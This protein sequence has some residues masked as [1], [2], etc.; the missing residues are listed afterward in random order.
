MD[1][2]ILKEVFDLTLFWE[3]RGF[4]MQGLWFNFE[5]FFFAW[6]LAVAGGFLVAL[7]RISP[8][9][10][11]QMIGT[12]YVELFRNLPDYVFLIW[13]HFVLPLLISRAI[14]TNVSFSPILSAVLG[15][16]I[17]YSGY[18]T[19][20]FRAGFQAVPRGHIKAGQ[21]LGM[22]GMLTVRRIILPQALRY[23][24][25]EVLNNSVSLFK[26]TSIVSLIAVPD[27]MYQVVVVVQEE[28]RPLSLYT[29]AALIYFVLIFAMTMSVR[30]LTDQWRMRGWA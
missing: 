28:M 12:L 15:L 21:S 1:V 25:P 17:S 7:L 16:G 19:E 14:N 18:L 9:R 22:H 20:T 8:W 26:A 23:M 6:L 30:K 24:L 4:L 10:I 27:L 3:Y 29:G 5:V 2:G 13:V 11:P